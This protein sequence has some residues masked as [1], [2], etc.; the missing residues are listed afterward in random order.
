MSG[1][2]FSGYGREKNLFRI[3]KNNQTKTN[4]QTARREN[5]VYEKI[6]EYL[7]SFSLVFCFVCSDVWEAKQVKTVTVYRWFKE[8]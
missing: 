5:I 1:C 7:N 3:K 2:G 8:L 4:Q 6:H